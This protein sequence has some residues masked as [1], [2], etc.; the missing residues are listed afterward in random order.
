MAPTPVFA[1]IPN[2]WRAVIGS[3]VVA[4]APH[5]LRPCI[6]AAAL[7]FAPFARCAAA[8]FPHSP[9]VPFAQQAAVAVV[10]LAAAPAAAVAAAARDAAVPVVYAGPAGTAPRR[11]KEGGAAAAA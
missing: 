4:A 10:V 6:L 11:G 7:L 3:A 2:R 8:W 5:V 9:P 1:A